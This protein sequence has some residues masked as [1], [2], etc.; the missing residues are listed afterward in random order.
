MENEAA[1]INKG[2]KALKSLMDAKTVAYLLVPSIFFMFWACFAVIDGT[3]YANMPEAKY[4]IERQRKD[5]ELRKT[6]VANIAAG[7][8]I[9]SRETMLDEFD[10]R[11][12]RTKA[13]ENLVVICGKEMRKIGFLILFGVTVQFYVVFKLRA[14]IKKLQREE[15][16]SNLSLKMG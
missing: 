4:V 10:V 8:P 5:I 1:P 11:D 7:S 14:H 12:K 9:P 3:D 16:D 2:T 15:I 13:W 6:V